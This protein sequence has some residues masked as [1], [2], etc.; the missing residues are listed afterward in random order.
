MIEPVTSIIAAWT[1]FLQPAPQVDRW[2]WLLVIP[3]ALGISLA[4]KSTRTRDLAN[5]PRETLRMTLQFVG[6][7]V[8]IAIVLYLVVIVLLPRLPAE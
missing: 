7:I 4:Y 1:P 3:T 5:L 6:A 8:G 2:W